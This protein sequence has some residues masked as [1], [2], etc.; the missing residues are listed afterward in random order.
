MPG[1]IGT[2]ISI[3]TGKVLTG[4]EPL[5][6]PAERVAQAR[7]RM[8]RAGAPVAGLSDDQIR[9]LLHQRALE[10]RDNAPTSAEQAAAIILTGVREDRWRILV[11]EDAQRLDAMVRAEPEQA[12]QD[13][14]AAAWRSAAT[15]PRQS[16]GDRA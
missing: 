4:T 11:G 1:H 8:L 14:F 10:F 3:N 13:A 15:T 12:Y 2:G 16:D 7:A 6:L 5:T 9:Q